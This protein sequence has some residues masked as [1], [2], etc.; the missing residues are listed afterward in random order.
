MAE[1]N[2]SLSDEQL[3]MAFQRDGDRLFAQLI[4]R[5]LPMVRFEVSRIRC[6][7]ADADDLAQ[8]ALLGL[9]SAAKTYRPSGGASFVSYARVCVRRRLLNAVNAL[10]SPELPHE[11]EH[12]FRELEKSADPKQNDPSEWFLDREEERLFLERL[13][14]RLSEL[15]YAVLTLHLSSYS[16]Q[17]T[18][19][20]LDVSS[21]AV[22]N[23]L[24][25]VRKKLADWL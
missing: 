24:R 22:D 20:I 2:S 19:R 6:N 12:L 7:R 21:K 25:R 9:L 15:E 13:R 14:K 17:E 11:D 18:A 4:E 23:A 10:S 8:E 3:V 1:Q 5:T 16:Y